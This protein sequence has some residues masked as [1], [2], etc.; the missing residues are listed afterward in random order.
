VWLEL[1]SG[2]DEREVR[3]LAEIL[4]GRGQC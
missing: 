2:F 4:W 1:E 3:I